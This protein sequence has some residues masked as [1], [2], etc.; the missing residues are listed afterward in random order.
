MTKVKI[1]ADRILTNFLRAN[2]NDVNSSRSGNWIY[3]D[4]PRVEDL[5]DTSFPRVGITLLSDDSD[6]MGIS[7][8]TQWHN[9]SI[10]IDVITKKDLAFTLTVTDEALGTVAATS[11]SNRMT[12]DFPPT[13]VT[14]I[15]HNTV[16]YGTVNIKGTDDDFT[17]PAADVMEVSFST[18]NVNFNATDLA[19]DVGE[20][21]TTTYTV[22]LEGKKVVEYLA[23]E[24]IKQIRTNWR[25][26][27]D[28]LG[29][30]KLSLTNSFSVPLD[31]D[32]GIYRHTVE[33]QIS[34]FNVG[35][36]L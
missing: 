27:S 20:A 9:I 31:E 26:D 24:I 36:G 15:K 13:T 29:I 28:L 12:Y 19:G 23:Q 21:I 35:E 10:Q 33:Y 7:D 25:S 2:L 32:I 11:N 30:Q 22:A 6:M 5:S 1:R 34:M 8:D 17:T 18:G 3:P 4:F 14:N 16:A